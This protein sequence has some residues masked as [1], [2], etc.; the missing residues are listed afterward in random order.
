[1]TGHKGLL[2]PLK[3]MDI[4]LTEACNL[5][6]SHCGAFS[7][8]DHESPLAI[9]KQLHKEEYFDLIAQARELGCALVIFSGGEPFLNPDIWEIMAYCDATE[10]TC[11][12]LTNGSLI[13]DVMLE[14]LMTLQK[15]AYIR[16]SLD[17][18]NDGKFEDARDFKDGFQ[19]ILNLTGKLSN[20]GIEVGIGMTIFDDNL[21]EIPE[22]AA[23]S[24]E[25]GAQFFRA[26]P[27]MPIGKAK[28][29]NVS[30]SF[31]AECVKHLL[32]LKSSYDTEYCGTIPM[33]D[34]LSE[35]YQSFLYTCSGAEENMSV[36]AYGQVGICSLTDL[37]LDLPT[38]REAP[39]QQ[40]REQLLQQKQA[41][42]GNIIS[43]PGFDCASC[44]QLDLCK[45]GCIAEVLARKEQPIT[46]Q[47][48]CIKEM[49]P[50][51]MEQFPPPQKIRRM[52]NNMIINQLMRKRQNT[53]LTCY[54]SLP[55]WFLDLAQEGGK[56]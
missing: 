49:W 4:S 26:I 30:R 1:M 36:N 52:V 15:L 39:L 16:L 55:F 8:R 7:H 19:K 6:C 14:K 50:D 21:A 24:R 53:L 33:S 38:I 23:L 32:K 22:L 28:D 47:P 43:K 40:I 17:Y 27:V 2:K 31:Y 51:I 25:H 46:A 11:A 12:I 3:V 10:I 34:D 29:R 41:Y 44:E 48:L 45:G 56:Q 18:I 5:Q 13:D 9:K 54:R 42:I 35:E 37:A 20:R